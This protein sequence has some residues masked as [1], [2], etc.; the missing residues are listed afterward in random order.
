MGC[1][2]MQKGKLIA[3]ASRQLKVH[4]KNYPIHDLDRDIQCLSNS[5]VR[6]DISEARKM[7]AY[8]KPRSSLLE[9]FGFNSLMMVIYV[10][11]ETRC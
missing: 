6:L 5:F 3:Y 11:L 7:L 1:T 2:L 4:E 10:R 8:M 9:R